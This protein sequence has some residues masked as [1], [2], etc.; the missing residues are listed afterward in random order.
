M[1]LHSKSRENAPPRSRRHDDT[2]IVLGVL[3]LLVAMALTGYFFWLQHSS[4]FLSR[5]AVPPKVSLSVTI[6][7]E[8]MRAKSIHVTQGAVVTPRIDV[9]WG[10]SKPY[11]ATVTL[12]GYAVEPG[13]PL[14]PLTF[15][16]LGYFTLEATVSTPYGGT[17]DSILLE[18]T[19]YPHRTIKV[20]LEQ[21]ELLENE[22]TMEIR[23]SSD[24]F[25]IENI[26]LSH[27]SLWLLDESNRDLDR[28]PVS[29]IRG[30]D[31]DYD[32]TFEGDS[33]IIRF[34]RS[35]DAP[36][37]DSIPKRFML[38]GTGWEDD[39]YIEFATGPISIIHPSPARSN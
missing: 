33:W 36:A 23:L 2:L 1:E 16:N 20:T 3:G 21:F 32:A 13:K 37:L 29:T 9:D 35:A 4:R 5:I 34:A 22:L 27:L 28:L 14:P 8:T 18:V 17:S 11:E 39:H 24:E 15:S 7:G 6:D 31:S 10:S 30:G 38:T 12:N 26:Y 19:A 25:N